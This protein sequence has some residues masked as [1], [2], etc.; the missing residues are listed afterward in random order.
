MYRASTT[1]L[2]TPQS[3]PEDFVRSTVTQRIEDRMASMTVQILS[4]SFL[5]Q[6]AREN[7]R[8]DAQSS[9]V[10]I[11][12]ECGRLRGRVEL[13]AG[14]NLSYFEV[15]A[16]DEN[17]ENAANIANRLASLFIGQNSQMRTEQATGTRATVES[18]LAKKKQEL[19]ETD[20]RIAAYKRGHQWELSEH[21]NS[22]L[23]M[24]EA[25]RS[26]IQGVDKE[27]QRLQERVADLQQ[28]AKLEQSLGANNNDPDPS[29]RQL[30]TLEAELQKLL[31]SYTEE[32]PVVRQKR[33]EIEEFRRRHPQLSQP[34]EPSS[35]TATATSTRNP[36]ID[37]A[38]RE[39]AS[40]KRDRATIESQMGSLT[41][42]IDRTPLRDQELQNLTR[43]YDQLKKEYE[44]LLAKRDQAIRAE[45]LET[46]RKSEQFRVQ[47]EARTPTVPFRPQPMIVLAICL[48]AGLG[49]GLGAVVILEFLDQS[50]KSEDEFREA[51][52]D[53]PLL[54]AVP[55]VDA[56]VLEAERRGRGRRRP[57]SGR[58]AAMTTVVAIGCETAR[59]LAGWTA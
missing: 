16:L 52:P 12:R 47:D 56:D 29:A 26:R 11:E 46:S 34:Q 43:G 7:G 55:H 59:I 49:L 44:D 45:E 23:E 18:W 14:K 15:A 57:P 37:R 58:H 38:E 40:L 25:N 17:P 3:L 19:D 9:E 2:V 27:I 39:I 48:A 32:N 50:L 31:V 1:I 35:P 54:S 33:S 6:V 21:L 10:E 30:A 41:S 5:E 28:A 36:E 22:N 51:F 13:E 42:R 53:V 20:A 8:L 4:R 24:L